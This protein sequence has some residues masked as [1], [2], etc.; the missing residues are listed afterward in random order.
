MSVIIQAADVGE[1]DFDSEEAITMDNYGLLLVVLAMA[2]IPVTIVIMF[3]GLRDAKE[4]VAKNTE[5]DNPLDDS[6]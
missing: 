4:D 3:V 1:A 2:G 6:K 5:F